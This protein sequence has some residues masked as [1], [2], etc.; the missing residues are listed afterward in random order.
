MTIYTLNIGNEQL[1]KGWFC[2]AERSPRSFGKDTRQSSMVLLG[3]VSMAFH[4]LHPAADGLAR[5]PIGVNGIVM[6]TSVGGRGE[7]KEP[8]SGIDMSKLFQLD[9]GHL[10]AL[11]NG[12]P[13]Y[14]LNLV[15]QWAHWQRHEE[16]RAM[17]RHVHKTALEMLEQKSVFTFY[18]VT[19]KYKELGARIEPAPTKR[20]WGVPV[21]FLVTAYLC[22]TIKHKDN[23]GY[24]ELPVGKD[25]KVT[26][27]NLKFEG[28][29]DDWRG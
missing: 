5:R 9:R 24:L 15:P 17:E 12:G 4:Y 14:E 21:S 11:Q 25:A 28:F 22:S 16:W 26:L 10:L 19:V 23:L 1:D 3:P 7:V 8:A 20:T 6:P 2:G 13:D 18:Q 29:P 27:N